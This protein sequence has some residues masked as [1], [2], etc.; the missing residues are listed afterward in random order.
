MMKKK[1]KIVLLIIIAIFTVTGCGSKEKVIN[2]KRNATATDIKAN[3]KYKV[4][5]KGKYV[6]KISSTEKISSDKKEK[7]DE[8]ENAYKSI[9]KAYDGL[10]YYDNKVIRDK[11]SVT[12]K[13]IINYEK[14]DT[15]KLIEIEGEEDNV[16]KNGK[17][18]L[19][20][21]MSFAKKLGT[22][23]DK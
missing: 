9:F 3:L 18:K 2:C 8:Y 22:T 13:T 10:K 16:I 4:Y 12:S 14:I 1:C 7:L 23:C 21:W 15:N 11:N 19:T 17:V 6:T 20:T 5:Y